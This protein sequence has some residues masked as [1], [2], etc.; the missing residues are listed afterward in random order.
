MGIGKFFSRDVRVRLTDKG[1]VE[2]VTW[3]GVT[4]RTRSWETCENEIQADELV[5]T[6]PRR[7]GAQPPAQPPLPR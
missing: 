6:R 3:F 4:R 5:R 7:D 2:T 1:F